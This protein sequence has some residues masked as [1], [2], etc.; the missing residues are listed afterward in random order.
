MAKRG[1]VGRLERLLSMVPWIAERDG[2]TID[3]ICTSF[4]I[5]RDALADDLNVVWMV[6]LHPFTPDELVEVTVADDRVW[7]RYAEYLA[8]PL[9]LTPEQ[10]LALIAAGAGMR[11]LEGVSIGGP[12]D[13]GLT[14]L[15]SL[16]GV[17]AAEMVDIEIGG[18]ETDTL[19]LLRSATEDLELSLIHI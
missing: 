3:E 10:G 9:Q 16:L 6:G 19:E 5:S 11:S 1:A 13:R 7:I 8:R 17:A 2:P 15:E 12:L 14:K 4:E 18:V